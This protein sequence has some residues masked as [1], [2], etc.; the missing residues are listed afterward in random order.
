MK[1]RVP[2]DINVGQELPLDAHLQPP[3]ANGE[4]I[5]EAPW[6]GRIFAIAVVLNDQGI[7]VWSEFQQ[8]L[9]D[10]IALSN[11]EMEPGPQKTSYQYFDHFQKALESLLVTKGIVLSQALEEREQA[12]AARPGGHDHLHAH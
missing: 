5:F 11:N 3:M 8:S 7:F 6:Q 4:V 10:T 2:L 1:N 9:I 12:F